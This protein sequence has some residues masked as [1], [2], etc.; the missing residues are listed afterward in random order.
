MKQEKKSIFKIH[1]VR[2]KVKSSSDDTSFDVHSL[3][4]FPDKGEGGTSPFSTSD[5]SQTE[6][7][8]G[9]RRAILKY[10]FFG[11]GLFIL[12]KIFGPS[13][14]LF[15]DDSKITDFKNFRVVESKLG[16]QFFDKMGNE[17]LALDKG[18]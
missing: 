14:N 11:S 12:G 16:L 3:L 4:S 5:S 10:A 9:N 6:I 18:E 17:I 15:G 13:L 7:P 8:N 1:D 2:K